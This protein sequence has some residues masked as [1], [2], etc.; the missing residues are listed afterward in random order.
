MREVV[1]GIKEIRGVL[2]GQN[3]V[4][5]KMDKA[6]NGEG[7]K[8]PGIILRLDRAERTIAGLVKFVWMILGATVSMGIKMIFDGIKSTGH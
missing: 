5:D 6:L 7:Q 3:R 1:A 2:E 8:E 4:M